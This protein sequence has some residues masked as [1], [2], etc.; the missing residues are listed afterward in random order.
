[1]GVIVAV[2]YRP[3]VGGESALRAA[4]RDHVPVLRAEGLATAREPIVGR[5][6]DGS[7]V[8][9]FEWRSQEAIDAAHANPAVAALW[10]R[11]G[12]C[13]EYVPIGSLGEAAQLFSAF[14]A[15]ELGD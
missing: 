2:C 3:K 5:A 8:E 14:E 9:V 6:R 1:M 15:V 4:L 10:E 7:F 13:C 11:F 12:T